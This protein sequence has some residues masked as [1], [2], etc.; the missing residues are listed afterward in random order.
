[1]FQS[2]VFQKSAEPSI[3]SSSIIIKIILFLLF[4]PLLL[5][6]QNNRI[7][8]DSWR[9]HLTYHNARSL[10]IGN[11]QIYVASENGLF[12]FDKNTQKITVLDKSEGLSDVAFSRLA[13]SENLQMLV[14]AYRN[15]NI[16]LVKSD[17]IVNVQ[18]VLNSRFEDKTIYHIYLNNDKAYFSTK[19]GVTILDL[20]TYQIL[21]T[22]DQIGDNGTEISAFACTI[23]QNKLFVATSEGLKSVPLNP[24]INRQDFRN[25]T[26]L[27][28]NFNNDLR[29]VS[30]LNDKIY[31]GINGNGTYVFDGTNSQILIETAGLNFVDISES[32]DKISICATDRLFIVENEIVQ[33]FVGDKIIAPRQL[34]FDT[35]NNLFL[36]DNF[37]GLVTQSGQ[38][39]IN[40][41]PSEVYTPEAFKVYNFETPTG[42]QILSIS[43]GYESDFQ[44]KNSQ[45]G[46]Y[47]FEKGIWKNY[48]SIDETG[49][50]V[51]IPVFQDLTASAYDPTTGVY[52]FASFG[53]GILIWNSNENSFESVTAENSIL[54]NNR[55]SDITLDFEGNL[56]IACF[57]V[58]ENEYSIL[59][60]RKDGSWNGRF[61][62]TPSDRF[63]TE[64]ISD[65]AG[66]IWIRLNP[67]YLGGILVWNPETGEEIL[68]D[69]A[70]LQGNLPSSKVRCMHLDKE[71]NLWVGTDEGIRIFYNSFA[72]FSEQNPQGQPV[73]YNFSEF[74]NNQKITAIAS[75]GGNRK[76]IGTENGVYL[77]DTDKSE[78]ISQFDEKNSP[79]LSDK[80]RSIAINDETGEVFFATD[81]GISS[82]Q[83]TSTK[84]GRSHQRVTV[85]P[86]PVRPEFMGKIAISGLV[87]DAN[88]KITDITGKLIFETFAQG[89]TAIWEG[90]NFTGENAKTGVYLVYSSN[91]D[92]TET[93][94]TKILLI[95]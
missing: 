10:A 46:F 86:N 70:Q 53:N 6:A 7:P 8:I 60:R 49:S 56:W 35:D 30:S 67:N 2:D 5:K 92:G 41:F 20:K 88:I 61:A 17:E 64:L 68:L 40:Y 76:W 93:F 52:Y 4:F 16:D 54:P 12:S 27:I 50:S 36:A 62:R 42:H 82:Y 29:T 69:D 39:F 3:F 66:N 37:F 63:P 78:I 25:W 31:F 57:N 85:F 77:F 81:K 95:K 74:L 94:V 23:S 33:D 1:M 22:Y 79:L 15:G 55:I 89:G 18:T 87:S 32:Q 72:I 91:E 26:T 83:G 43:G 24:E 59:Q 84:S 73:V 38:S 44:P 80:I 58:A 13:Y 90:K 28:P 47:I 75:D 11:N 45:N 21:E 65:L 14:V 19:F 71:D 48:N 9:S 51:A 34:L